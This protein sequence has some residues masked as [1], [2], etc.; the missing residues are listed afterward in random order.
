MADVVTS[1]LTTT[2][3]VLYFVAPAKTVQLKGTPEAKDTFEK[4][5]FGHYS[6]LV[7]LRQRIQ[8]SASPMGSYY[9]KNSHL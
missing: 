1:A 7:K 8:M 5:N 3:L 6:Q 4:V 9:V 2:L